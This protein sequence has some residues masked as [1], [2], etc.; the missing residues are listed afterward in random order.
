MHNTGRNDPCPCKSGKKYKHCCQASTE[1]PALR[2]QA[3]QAYCTRTFQEALARHQRGEIAQAKQLYERILEVDKDHAEALHLL[4]VIAFQV[5][6]NEIAI[7]FIGRALEIEPDFAEAHCNLANALVSHGKVEAAVG[8]LRTALKLKPDFIDAH[9]KLGDTLRMLGRMDEAAASCRHAIELQPTNPSGYIK[10]GIVLRSQGRFED[11]LDCFKEAIRIDPQSPETYSH[12]GSILRGL[13]NYDEAIAC[14]RQALQLNPDLDEIESALLFS[15]NYAAHFAP[16]Q[17]LGEARKYGRRV[18]GKVRSHFSNWSAPSLP[19]RLRV[20]IVSGDLH[21]HPVAFFLEGLL[22]NIDRRRIELIAYHAH[23]RWDEVTERLRPQFDNWKLIARQNDEEAARTIHGD[24]IQVL[25][26]MSG[27]TSR[28]RLPVFAWK[29]APVQA[30]WLGYFA[31]TGL[32]E[33]DYALADPYV[34][35]AGEED[36]FTEAVWRLPESYL[37]FT[38][39]AVDLDVGPLP[40]LATGTVTYGSFNNLAKMNDAVVALWARV[41]HAAPG[42]RLFLKTKQLS[43]PATCESTRQRFQTHGIAAERLILEG[44]SPR[45]ELLAAYNR[46]DVALDPFPYPGGTTSVEAMWMGVPVITRRGDRFLSRVGESIAFNAGLC[47]S[48][49]SDNDDYVAKAASYASGLQGLAAL[50]GNLRALVMGSPLFDAPRFARHF[51]TALFGMWQQYCDRS[52]P[53]GSSP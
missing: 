26:D 28:N 40:A 12:A 45:H 51:E 1:S 52:G 34:V 36:Q 25:L 46:V 5:G 50:R 33:M 35:P 15:L 37:C 20:G 13:G 49:A 3:E 18:A 6:K 42:S 47:D 2:V 44:P 53:Q 38:P 29:P 41:L 4:G 10:L 19:D 21:R 31:T 7:Q 30:T 48:V 9:C 39:P 27:H 16:S 24:G 43:S 14:F 11:A 23:N 32:A 8:S 22:A 17:C